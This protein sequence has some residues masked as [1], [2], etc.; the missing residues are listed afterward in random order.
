MRAVAERKTR[1][2]IHRGAI[3]LTVH[4]LL[5]YGAG[6]LFI[7][8]TFLFSFE[9]DGPKVLAALVGA[10]LL[11][12]AVLADAPTGLSRTLPRAS[13]IVLDYVLS[14]FLLASPFLFGFTDDGAALAF[15]LV[16]GVAFLL[17]T[18][19]TRFYKPDERH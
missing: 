12:M 17:L 1:R 4:G 9:T 5:E 18:L 16:M 8:S 14:V 11:V 6:V 10:G 3:P 19:M 2:L 15:F 13:H 7:A